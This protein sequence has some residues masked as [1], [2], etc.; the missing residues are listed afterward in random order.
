MERKKERK[1]EERKSKGEK[2]GEELQKVMMK[3]PSY[4]CFLKLFTPTYNSNK[5]YFP[6]H[7]EVK[8]GQMRILS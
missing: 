7:W 6:L 5:F 2:V 8:S 1:R 3:V 4:S